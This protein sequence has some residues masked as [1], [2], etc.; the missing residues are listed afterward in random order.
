MTLTITASSA[1][2]CVSASDAMVLDISRQAVVNAGADASICEGSA[3][4]VSGA[5]STY[6]TAYLWATSGTGTFDDATTLNPVYSPS[7]ADITA[8]AVT[9]TIT[10]SRPCSDATDAWSQHQPRGGVPICETAGSYT[11][12]GAVAREVRLPAPVYPKCS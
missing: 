8:G 12:A 4:T 11:L 7:V 2:P 3:Y 9:L 10:A 1:A 6:A 5:S